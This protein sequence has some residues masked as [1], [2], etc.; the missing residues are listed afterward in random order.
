MFHCKNH[1]SFHYLC[2]DCRRAARGETEDDSQ[3]AA[4]RIEDDSST[5]LDTTLAIE[6]GIALVEDLVDSSDTSSSQADGF[7]AGNDDAGFSGGGAG[8]DF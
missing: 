8:G 3:Q 5:A 2:Y 6:G 4:A 7:T 1:A